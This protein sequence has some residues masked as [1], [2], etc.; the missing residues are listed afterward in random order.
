MHIADPLRSVIPSLDGTVYSALL[1]STA[2]MTVSE[3]WHLGGAGTRSGVDKVLRRLDAQGLAR[4]Q[5]RPP[6]YVLNRDHVAFDGLSALGTMRSTVLHRLRDL[7]ED[8]DL[9]LFGLFGSFARGDGDAESDIDVLLVHSDPAAAERFVAELVPR[10]EGWTGNEVQVVSYTPSEL[11]DVV[12]LGEPVVASWREELLLI[13]GDVG[14]LA[15][16][17]H[18]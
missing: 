13:A 3:V 8:K 4:A 5:G 16:A 18:V 10:L 2:P 15:T 1:R 6:R 12:G 9:A 7:S 17:A 11:A 14:L